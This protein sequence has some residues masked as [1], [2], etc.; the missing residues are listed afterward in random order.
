MLALAF[1]SYKILSKENTSN[2]LEQI[3]DIQTPEDT[4]RF[5][6][7]NVTPL[8]TKSTTIIFSHKCTKCGN[9]FR[10]KYTL[11]SNRTTIPKLTV[12]CGNCGKKENATDEEI[13]AAEII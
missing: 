7:D 13:D 12:I 9:V 8:N 6:L 2:E 11:E 4:V 1:A 3:D 10:A 5:N